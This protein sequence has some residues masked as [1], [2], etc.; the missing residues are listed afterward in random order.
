MRSSTGTTLP[1]HLNVET[2]VYSQKQFKL[3]RMLLADTVDK[4]D[5]R[6]KYLV[7][8]A[9]PPADDYELN[10]L[11]ISADQDVVRLNR[12]DKW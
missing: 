9:L 7:S 1:T 5:K 6:R 4:I 12:L 3:L 11:Y 2:E 8:M 10:M